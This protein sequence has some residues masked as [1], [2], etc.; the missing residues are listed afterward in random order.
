MMERTIS[1]EEMRKMLHISKRKAKYLLDEGIIP[2]VNT[3]KLTRQYRVNL[4]DVEEYL[5]CTAIVTYKSNLDGVAT[6]TA[7]V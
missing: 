1:Q 4:S 7:S 5:L 2:C 3:G 6:D